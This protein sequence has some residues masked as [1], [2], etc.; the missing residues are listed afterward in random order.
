MA[1]SDH[2]PEQDTVRVLYLGRLEPSKGVELLCTAFERSATR[3]PALR[4]DV[5]GGGTLESSLRRRYGGHPQMTFHG[6]VVGA[7][8]EAL[9]GN[10][11]VVVVP[12]VWPE[13]F[14]L[15]TI[16]ALAAGTPVIASEVGAL[17]ELVRHG[18]TGYVLPTGDVPAWTEALCR[19]AERPDVVRSM[20]PA[21]FDAAQHYS[22]DSVVDQ[23][24][25][26][27]ER[28]L[29]KAE[30]PPSVEASRLGRDRDH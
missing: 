17:P 18:E 23:Y 22:L 26:L 20:R 6:V 14:G 19:L 11:D 9:L 27:Y 12:S 13:A 24:V 29:K 7:E 8:K 2:L 15:V 5:A 1:H 25:R 28:T 21:C 10:S 16:E 30:A 4:L 3:C